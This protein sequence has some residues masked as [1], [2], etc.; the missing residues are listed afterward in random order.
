MANAVSNTAAVRPSE[1]RF[2][3]KT[4]RQMSMIYQTDDIKEAQRQYRVWFDPRSEE[5]LLDVG[6]G[7]GVNTHALSKLVGPAGKIIGIDPSPA[8]LALAREKAAAPNIEY[9]QLAVED[10]PFAENTFDGIVCT[11]VFNYVADPVAVLKSLLRV[12]RPTGRIFLSETDWDT[13]SYNI[14]D[15][16][17]QRRVTADF[18]DHHGDGWMGRKLYPIC[19]Q[20]NARDIQVHPYVIS[21]AEYSVRKYGGPMSYVIRDYLLRGKGWS[22]ADVQRWT[23]QLSEAYDNKSYFFSLTRMVCIV[24]K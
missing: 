17:L 12:V 18:S 3:E 5:V 2:D 4:A 24:R 14:P 21:N 10:I 23:A 19:R 6:C 13:L 20:A 16:E 15:K 8:M 7:T 1:V 9:Q 22:E 11:Q